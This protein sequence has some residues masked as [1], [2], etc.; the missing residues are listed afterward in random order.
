MQKLPV[1]I[2]SKDRY[3]LIEQSNIL[4]KQLAGQAVPYQLNE[5]GY[6]TGT[7]AETSSA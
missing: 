7:C 5:S 2:K 3:T 1:Q 4:L 6:A